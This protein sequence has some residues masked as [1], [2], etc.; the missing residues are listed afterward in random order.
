MG[1]F[2]GTG[3]FFMSRFIFQRSLQEFVLGIITVA[4]IIAIP[5]NNRLNILGIYNKTIQIVDSMNS[6][7]LKRYHRKASLVGVLRVVSVVVIVFISCWLL[8]F[9]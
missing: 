3:M 1:L 6:S 9:I 7:D 4:A 5:I 8:T 2:G